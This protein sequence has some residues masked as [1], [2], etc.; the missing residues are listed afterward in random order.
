MADALTFRQ[1]LLTQF[2]ASCHATPSM[3]SLEIALQALRYKRLSLSTRA[4]RS[5]ELG[6]LVMVATRFDGHCLLRLILKVPNI[7]L[8]RIVGEHLQIVFAD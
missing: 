2:Q 7:D 3:S 5:A 1:T 4:H 6:S 8:T